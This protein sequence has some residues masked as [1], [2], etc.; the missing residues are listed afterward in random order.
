MLGRWYWYQSFQLTSSTFH[1]LYFSPFILFQE[2]FWNM[3][4]LMSLGKTVSL[5]SCSFFPLKLVYILPYNQN[6]HH[7]ISYKLCRNTAVMFVVVVFIPSFRLKQNHLSVVSECI[8][9]VC[10]F[11]NQKDIKAFYTGIGES[12][13]STVYYKYIRGF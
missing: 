11:S 12:D 1:F 9:T 6:R 4:H 5:F 3:V 13:P 7:L 2:L 10:S 8:W